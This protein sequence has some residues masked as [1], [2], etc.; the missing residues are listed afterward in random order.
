MQLIEK[1]I[2]KIEFKKFC[3]VQVAQI[4]HGT[5]AGAYFGILGFD[6]PERGDQNGD[7]QENSIEKASAKFH[8]KYGYP[9]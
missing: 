3:L 5:H 2:F 8:F 4:K 6:F 9:S 7:E 1:L